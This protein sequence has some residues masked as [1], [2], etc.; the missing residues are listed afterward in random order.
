MKAVG[1]QHHGFRTLIHNHYFMRLW[2][3][4]LISQTIM[5]AANYAL[6]I[7]TQQSGSGSFT[8]AAGAIVAFSLPALLFG[9]P[10]GVLVDR[11]DRRLVLW[12]SN[13]LRAIASVAFVFVL[14]IDS[15]PLLPVY[16]LAFFM[17]MVGQF[18]APAEGAAIP[19]L[20]R[21]EEMDRGARNRVHLTRD[22]LHRHRAAL[23]RLRRPGSL[24][25]QGAHEGVATVA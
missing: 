8:A 12:V 3:A 6:I 20:V 19:L 2:L 15:T 10:A 22:P 25:P 23:S 5:N 13:L 9:A 21:R 14:M 18:F 7:V 11:F 24:A 4:Q 1:T 17:A 16:I